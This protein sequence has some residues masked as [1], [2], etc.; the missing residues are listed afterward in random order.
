M[1]ERLLEAYAT[2]MSRAPGAAFRKARALYL[3]KYSLPQADEQTPLKLFV[4]DE[5]LTET[6][7][8]IDGGDPQER[9][10]TLRSTPGALALVHWQ[11]TDPAP[12]DLVRHYFRQS[13]GLDPEPLILK[14]W[15]E[16]WFRNGGH[17]IR[18]TSP[19]GLFIQQQ[20]LLWL[21]E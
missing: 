4:C 1:I 11:Q 9:L 17:Q 2:L 10:V 18:I 15:P 5:Q 7:E 6:V 12:D 19:T 13:W 16:P 8:P 21:S 20:S 3:N 14:A